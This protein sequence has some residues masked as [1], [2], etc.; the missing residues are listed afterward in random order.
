MTARVVGVFPPRARAVRRH[1]FDALE[2][3]F[4]IR[5]E[6]REQGDFGGLDAAV[7]VAAPAPTQRPP[8]PSLWFERGDVERPHSG[9]VRL[10]ID[11]L[12]DGRLR[13]RVLTDGKADA[14]PVL[15]PSFPA[16]VLAATANGPV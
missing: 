4:P 11:T 14:A 8:C 3:A 5:F 6:G 9:K 2:L 15:R 12:L 13:G 16:R 1:L 10:S 7:F